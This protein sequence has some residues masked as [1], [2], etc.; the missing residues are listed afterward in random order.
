MGI[1]RK[2]KTIKLGE[3]QIAIDIKPNSPT[4]IAIDSA[5]SSEESRLNH[6]DP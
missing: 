3:N 5:N 2:I 4:L 6:K 1:I